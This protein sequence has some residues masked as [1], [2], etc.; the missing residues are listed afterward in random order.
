M[1]WAALLVH[2]TYPLHG[3]LSLQRRQGLDR[4]ALRTL[5]IYREE[6][7]AADKP[8]GTPT[9]ASTPGAPL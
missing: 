3:R 8:S 5:Q 9:V 1:L 7:H 4:Q 6:Y 2:A